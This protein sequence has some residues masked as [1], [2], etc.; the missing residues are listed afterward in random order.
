MKAILITNDEIKRFSPIKGGLDDDKLSS[1]IEVAQEIHLQNYLGSKLYDAIQVHALADTMP[2]DYTLLIDKYC[3][4][5]LM[6]WALVEFMP[7]AAFTI[8]NNG[9]FKHNSE[10][11]TSVTA[12]E[13]VALTNKYTRIATHY[14]Q[15]LVD[16]LCDNS[17]LYPEYNDNIGS[18]MKPSRNTNYGGLY[19]D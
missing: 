4:P 2:E 17:T 13:I 11:S 9:V 10:N 5:M 6:R 8:A 19:L 1:Y 14:T 16:Y 15:L 18:D 7:F 3:K 12:E